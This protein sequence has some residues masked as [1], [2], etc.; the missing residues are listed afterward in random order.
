MKTTIPALALSLWLLAG[1]CASPVD[2]HWG[3]SISATQAA[4]VNDPAAPADHEPRVDLD[5]NS[6]EA[7]AERYYRGQRQQSTRVA[8]SIV[9]TEN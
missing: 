1:G 3:E 2:E 6:A 9:I 7:V 4:Q 5:A 8:P